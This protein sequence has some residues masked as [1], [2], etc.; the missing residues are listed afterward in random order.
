MTILREVQSRRLALCVIVATSA[1]LIATPMASAET[2][3][4]PGP[5]RTDNGNPPKCATGQW[6]DAVLDISYKRNPNAALQQL[7]ADAS[8]F[9]STDKEFQAFSREIVVQ[10][11]NLQQFR[12]VKTY[13]LNAINEMGRKDQNVRATTV[14]VKAA[15]ALF[16]RLYRTPQE[17]VKVIKLWKKQ[18]AGAEKKAIAG[19]DKSAAKIIRRYSVHKLLSDQSC[20]LL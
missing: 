17:A 10:P 18:R 15:E 1:M 9:W 8:L 12:C 19:I 16:G 20:D 11:L 6:W 2:V 14:R 3:K 7:R 5:C 4:V 13:L